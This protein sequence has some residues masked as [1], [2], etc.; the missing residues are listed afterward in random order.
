MTLVI[1]KEYCIKENQKLFCADLQYIYLK[2]ESINNNIFN[3]CY[4]ME[5][6]FINCNLENCEFIGSILKFAYFENCNLKNTS[7]K[8]CNIDNALFINCN[9]K[10]VLF[11]DTSL[12]STKIDINCNL[13][14]CI[15]NDTTLLFAE[16]SQKYYD[17]IKKQEPDD[18]NNIIW[19]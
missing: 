10:N 1:T 19:I 18:F 9:L 8:K 4:L 15:F 16:I 13:E 17:Y 14:N 7:F 2:D 12:F 5:T 3:G 6:S 11:K